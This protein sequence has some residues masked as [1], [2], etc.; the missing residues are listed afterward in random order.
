MAHRISDATTGLIEIVEEISHDPDK[1][2]AYDLTEYIENLPNPYKVL[3]E[4]A[5]WTHQ[6]F[7]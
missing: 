2:D 5:L 4:F 1:F 7:L 6:E 3:K